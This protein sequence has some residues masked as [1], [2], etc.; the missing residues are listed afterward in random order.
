MESFMSTSGLFVKFYAQVPESQAKIGRG[1]RSPNPISHGRT[2]A[3][4][5]YWSELLGRLS[6]RFQAKAS[7]LRSA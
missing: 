1:K 3:V 6:L 7:I 4:P 2:S 5:T